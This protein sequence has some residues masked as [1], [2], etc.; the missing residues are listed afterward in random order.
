M[1]KRKNWK[2]LHYLVWQIIKINLLLLFVFQCSF[3][4]LPRWFCNSVLTFI[5]ILIF[6][7]L[8]IFFY[9]ATLLTKIRGCFYFFL[10]FPYKPYKNIYY[11]KLPYYVLIF[12]VYS[13]IE[14]GMPVHNLLK[15]TTYSLASVS[16]CMYF[17]SENIVISVVKVVQ[18]RQSQPNFWSVNLLSYP[19]EPHSWNSRF[20]RCC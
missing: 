13:H 20:F 5:F 18:A 12:Y 9:F 3:W 1:G 2:I 15:K 11:T 17:D 10:F 6:W 19:K 4:S 16:L 14:Y 7:Q 8:L